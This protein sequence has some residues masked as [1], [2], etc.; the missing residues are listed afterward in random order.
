[1]S[2]QIT[3][4]C[5]LLVTHITRIFDTFIVH[6]QSAH[7][8]VKYA[9]DQCGKQFTEDGSLTKHNQSVHEG[10]MYICS[11][12]GHQAT[13]QSNLARHIQSV[14]EGVK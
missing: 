3:L 10:V 4:L 14:H 6:I 12:C 1:M 9:C 8:G 11:Q 2:C 7:E 5:K 13:Q